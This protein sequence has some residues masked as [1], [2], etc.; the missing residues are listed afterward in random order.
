MYFPKI[1]GILRIDRYDCISISG[2]S[3]N[4]FVLEKILQHHPELL[5]IIESENKTE[6][7][8]FLGNNPNIAT[9]VLYHMASLDNL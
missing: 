1:L 4:L 9:E 6:L 7:I 8:K 2:W 3:A 5:K